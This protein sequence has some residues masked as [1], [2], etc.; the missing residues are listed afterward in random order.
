MAREHLPDVILMDIKLPDISGIEV[1]GLLR[2]NTA[3]AAIPV[4]ALSSNAYPRQIEHG[5]TAGFQ[6]YLTK[7]F[8]IND[9]LD[10]LDSCLLIAARARQ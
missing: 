4:M 3:T 2:A 10:A 7:P 6:K 8:R 9:F 5:E 1:L